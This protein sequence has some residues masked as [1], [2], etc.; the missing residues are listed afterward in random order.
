MKI[1]LVHNYYR[2]RGGE[3]RYFESVAELL[4]N[5]GHTIKKYSEDSSQITDSLVSKAKIGASLQTSYLSENFKK[6]V[7]QF[8]PHIVHFN[9][10]YPLIGHNAYLFCKAKKIPI[11]QTIHN[12]R[13][14]CPKGILFRDG[15]ICEDCVLKNFP[16]NSILHACY[17]NSRLASLAISIALQKQNSIGAV[18]IDRFIFPSNFT[19]NYYKKTLNIP[20]EKSA[21][22]YYFAK[23]PKT[24]TKT[25]LPFK[26]YILF[27]GRL[28]EEKGILNL[29]HI[30]SRLPDINLVI[31]GNGPLY[32]KLTIYT[33]CPNI[34][35]LGFLSNTEIY[36]YQKNAL[37]T[38]IP[39]RWYETGPIVLIESYMSK[40]PVIA[41]NLGSFTEQIIEGKTGYLYNTGKK[42]SLK[43]TI[44]KVWDS[45]NTQDTLKKHA[46]EKYLSDYQENIHYNKLLKIYKKLLVK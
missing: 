28:S 25:I 18:N 9:N 32:K 10:I 29:A 13:S 21:V 38:I 5:K 35:M 39:S 11:I 37:C 6:T 20:E 26:K 30:I 34:K 22:I 8:N 17:N 19:K 15:R 23:L 7:S 44:Q 4:T 46:W 2:Y 27:V 1:L 36:N 33:K 24:I 12:Y 41:P 40:T 42:D 14:I 31:I 43:Q 3:D 16:A 45:P